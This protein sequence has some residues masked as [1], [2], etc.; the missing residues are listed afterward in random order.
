MESVDATTITANPS[1]TQTYKILSGIDESI[2]ITAFTETDRYCDQSN[3]VYTM[4]ITYQTNSQSTSWITFNSMI[5]SWITN[6][7]LNVGVYDITIT[8][9]LGPRNDVKTFTA[10]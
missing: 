5:V 6:D 10:T 7:N 2:A 1:S 8:G 9:V 4:S 3:I